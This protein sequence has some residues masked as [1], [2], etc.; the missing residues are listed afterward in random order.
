ML[1]TTFSYSINVNAETRQYL[2]A[3]HIHG[4]VTDAPK[5]IIAFLLY[6][7]A[8]KIL[9][10]R[11]DDSGVVDN[12]TLVCMNDMTARPRVQSAISARYQV[13]GIAQDHK[14]HSVG[15]MTSSK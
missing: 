12:T 15:A 4:D 6:S 9:N 2:F 1:F 11:T 10:A 13:V 7:I 3:C 8:Y 5:T 14:F